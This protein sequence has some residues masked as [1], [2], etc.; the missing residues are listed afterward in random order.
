MS[1]SSKVKVQF[2]GM[3]SVALSSLFVF[4]HVFSG[5]LLLVVVVFVCLFSSQKRGVSTEANG[6]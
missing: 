2:K 1:S 4:I 5:P 3:K 6:K